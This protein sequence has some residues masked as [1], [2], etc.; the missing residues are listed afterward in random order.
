MSYPILGLPTGKE[1]RRRHILF[2]FRDVKVCL[3]VFKSYF[4]I[5]GNVLFLA[6]HRQQ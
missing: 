1:W 2:L 3:I 5:N 6:Y 4:W